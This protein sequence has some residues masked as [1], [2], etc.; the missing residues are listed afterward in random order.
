MEK[1]NLKGIAQAKLIAIKNA[2]TEKKDYILADSVQ[3]TLDLV[4]KV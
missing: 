3:A 4:A 1:P 2:L